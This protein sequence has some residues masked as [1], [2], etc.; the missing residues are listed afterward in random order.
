M[1]KNLPN[2]TA[3]LMCLST[4]PNYY[5]EFFN[6]KF[7]QFDEHFWGV[8]FNRLVEEKPDFDDSPGAI[9]FFLSKISSKRNLVFKITFI[10]LLNSTNLKIGFKSFFKLYVSNGIYNDYTEYIY[11]DLKTPLTARNFYPTKIH[12]YSEISEVLKNYT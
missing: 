3:I 8:L 11:K 2:E 4:H 7:K 12:T 5:F 6:K 9:I 10:K 1:L